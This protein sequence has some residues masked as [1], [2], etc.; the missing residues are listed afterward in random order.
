MGFEFLQLPLQCNV[1][2][3]TLCKVPLGRTEA[4]AEVHSMCMVQDTRHVG[5]V[6]ELRV[7]S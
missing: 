1:L 3:V 5:V 6:F 4:M 7:Q 2:A